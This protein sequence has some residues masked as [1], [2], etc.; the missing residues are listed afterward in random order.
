MNS[1]VQAAPAAALFTWGIIESIRTRSNSIRIT[2]VIVAG[3]AGTA[4]AYIAMTI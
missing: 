3:I 1:L 2:A 4:V